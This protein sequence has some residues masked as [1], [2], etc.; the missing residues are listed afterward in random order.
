MGKENLIAFI[1]KNGTDNDKVNL[2]RLGDFQLRTIVQRLISEKRLG[3]KK[4]KKLEKRF[5]DERSGNLEYAIT[6]LG[7]RRIPRG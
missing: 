1:K 4:T 5:I 3:C 6:A 2:I 7:R